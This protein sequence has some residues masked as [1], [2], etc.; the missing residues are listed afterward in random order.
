M[1]ILIDTDELVEF[2]GEGWCS[3]DI[4]TKNELRSFLVDFCKQ[5]IEGEEEKEE[6][7]K[8]ETGPKFDSIMYVTRDQALKHLEVLRVAI[9]SMGKVSIRDYYRFAELLRILPEWTSM[10]KWTPMYYNEDYGWT[11]LF[12]ARVKVIHRRGIDLWILEMPEP[13]KLDI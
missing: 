6:P 9:A 5:K 1:K 11:D 4:S 13:R 7:A 10:P 12:M 3:C 2:F 8:S